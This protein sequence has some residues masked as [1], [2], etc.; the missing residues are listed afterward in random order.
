MSRRP[1]CP[2]FRAWDYFSSVEGAARFPSPTVLAVAKQIAHHLD[3]EG[4][5]FP[6]LERLAAET[7]LT[8]STV[9]RAVQVLC[10]VDNPVYEKTRRGRRGNLFNLRLPQP[11]NLRVEQT[12]TG[13]SLRLSNPQL[14][15]EQPSTCVSRNP[16]P[17]VSLSTEQDSRTGKE[18]VTNGVRGK[19]PPGFLEVWSDYPHHGQRSKKIA[20]AR[21]WKRDRLEPL[22]G[23]I[24]AWIC[25][26]KQTDDWRKENGRYVPGIQSWL[27][28]KDFTDSPPLV[29]QLQPY[30]DRTRKNLEAAQRFVGEG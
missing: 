29:S 10:D 3:R 20:A 18:Q 13:D 1:A 21:I 24:R 14:A 28:G 5:C 16:N 19:Y 6:S 17:S 7:G 8:P 23:N 12:K 4:E 2:K 25:S 26:G 22:A 11:N 9:S 27:N 30:S 15:S